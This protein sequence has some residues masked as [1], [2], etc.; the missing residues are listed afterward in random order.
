MH[1]LLRRSLESLTRRWVFR[2]RLP[3]EF[4][5]LPIWVTPAAS[6]AF[7][8]SMERANWRELYDFA[9]HCVRPSDV[10]WDIGA[11]VGVFS[12]CAAHCAGPAGS[13][14]AVEADPWLAS[15]LN[16]SALQPGRRARVEVLCAAA[17]DRSGL[18]QF[19]V[20]GRTRSG[21][22]LSVV[23]GAGADLVGGTTE[24]LTV[25]GLPL[26]WLLAHRP[27]PQVLKLDVEGAELLVLQGARQ[28]LRDHRPILLLEAHEHAAAAI[29]E[30]LH[31]AGYD[32]FDL[33][34]GWAERSPADL[35]PY[36]TLALPRAA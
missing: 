12:F 4:G 13:V 3:A 9:R 10:V 23:P 35:A 6:L 20:S 34:A 15:L 28:L 5:R 2:R 21:S 32:L 31:A 7:L 17:A 19:E 27:A 18:M 26:D 25:A 30:L 14:L 33:G 22:H 29:T 16:R 8:R 1:R 11:N 24:T 36:H